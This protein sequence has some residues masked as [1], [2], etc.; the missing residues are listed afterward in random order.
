MTT[1]RRL[2]LEVLGRVERGQYASLALDAALERSDLSSADRAFATALVYGVLEKRRRLDFA[3]S[4]LSARPLSEIGGEVAML[5]RLGLYQL[6][7]LDRVPDHAA[8]N[9]TVALASRKTAGFVNAIL[10]AFIRGGKQLPLPEKEPLDEWLAVRYSVSPAL[11]SKLL[12]ELGSETAEAFLSALE[13]PPP[14]TL[15]VN[16][17]RTSREAL[18]G[19]LHAQGHD[20]RP[21]AQSRSGILL[22]HGA[23][24]RSLAGFEE[25]DFFVQ[26]E[27]SQLAVEALD[28]RSGMRVLDVC[29]CPGSKSFGLAIEMGGAGELLS[30]DLHRSKLSLV[31]RGAERLGIGCLTVAERD[32]RHAFPEW[33]GRADR[34]LCDVPC[35]G[36]GVIGKK[37]ELR[38]KDPAESAALPD[39]QSAILARSATLLRRGG[40]LVYSTCT[41]LPDENERNVA[42]FLAETDGFRLLT[43]RT[44]LPQIDGT[45]GF[46]FAVLERL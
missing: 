23:P 21:T 32:A 16:T 4:A 46:Y 24:I 31:K 36:F 37:P 45:D 14:L 2:A 11:A 18:L 12:A 28:A 40:R 6:A 13:T 20:A 44:L 9:E 3:L 34:V 1:P 38:E 8:V 22:P 41:I 25:G 27:A 33:E 30:C 43:E 35:S 10:R 26:D 7:C 5:L 42:R 29:A 39:I 19:R 15:R 17:L